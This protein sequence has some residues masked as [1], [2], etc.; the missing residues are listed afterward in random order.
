MFR[1]I[2][3][4]DHPIVRNGLRQIISDE[5]DLIVASEV[6]NAEQLF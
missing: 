6:A 3:A 1:I 4:D 5:R 2:I